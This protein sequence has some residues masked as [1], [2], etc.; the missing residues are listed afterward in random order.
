MMTQ[1]VRTNGDNTKGIS[2][3]AIKNAV[4]YGKNK[5]LTGVFKHLPLSDNEKEMLQMIT[6]RQQ[7]KFMKKRLIPVQILMIFYVHKIIDEAP[8][9]ALRA[10]ALIKILENR[11]STDPRNQYLSVLVRDE[12]L[13]EFFNRYNPEKETFLKVR[14]EG[15]KWVPTS[16]FRDQAGTI[17]K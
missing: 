17:F 10:E 7:R 11:E 14:G 8:S 2:M 12:M 6:P 16:Y 9:N 5:R 4:F 1:A 3:P 13:S 15:R